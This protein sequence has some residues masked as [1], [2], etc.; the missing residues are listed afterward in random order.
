MQASIQRSPTLGRRDALQ[1]HSDFII[2][3]ARTLGLV[4]RLP[5]RQAEGFPIAQQR[6]F[7]PSPA[8]SQWLQVGLERERSSPLRI[9]EW[10]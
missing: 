3:T 7:A 10:E 4:S 1:Y 6:P 5:L 8:L 9:L 2:E